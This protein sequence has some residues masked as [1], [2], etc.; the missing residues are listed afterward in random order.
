MVTWAQEFNTNLGNIA[1]SYFKEKKKKKKE[2]REGGR[3]EGRKEG[4]KKKKKNN[5]LN[6][7]TLCNIVEFVD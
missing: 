4:E 3:K 7:D 6:G 5:Y 1:R 2:G